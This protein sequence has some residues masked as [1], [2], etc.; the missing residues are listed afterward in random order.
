MP[1]HDFL[2]APVVNPDLQHDLPN[3]EEMGIPSRSPIFDASWYVTQVN[4]QVFLK[5]AF[6]DS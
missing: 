5:L 6:K 2:S 1:D 3:A 4:E